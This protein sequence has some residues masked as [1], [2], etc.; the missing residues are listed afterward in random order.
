M[1]KNKFSR[2]GQQF[3]RKVRLKRHISK[4]KRLGNWWKRFRASWV[5][6][7]SGSSVQVALPLFSPTTTITRLRSQTDLSVNRLDN[8]YR[9]NI[10]NPVTNQPQ[11]LDV[12]KRELEEAQKIAVQL[13]R[14]NVN[15]KKVL[16][17]VQGG[18]YELVTTVLITW[19]W[20]MFLQNGGIDGFI[21]HGNKVFFWPN[22]NRYSDHPTLSRFSDYSQSTYSNNG[23]S[24]I[25][26]HGSVQANQFI[27]EMGEVDI[28]KGYK[29]LKQRTK[30][31]N[32]ECTQKRFNEL[33]K[34]PFHPDYTS[35]PNQIEMICDKEGLREALSALE[36]EAKGQIEPIKRPTVEEYKNCPSDFVFIKRTATGY[37]HFEIKNSVSTE[38]LQ[39]KGYNSNLYQHGRNMSKKCLWQKTQWERKNCKTLCAIDFNDSALKERGE[40]LK[41]I[42]SG[43]KV[44]NILQLKDVG[45]LITNLKYNN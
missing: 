34:R 21:I 23:D 7:G 8:K 4:R 32:F 31:L 18:E 10:F 20:I 3:K 45:I 11:M 12:T 41:G 2:F 35:N 42:Y 1:I 30:D 25:T 29:E 19:M 33:C 24:T 38:S 16:G 14:N 27:N 44:S 5:I 36:M 13:Y 17:H 37:T 9:I 26:R 15:F 22:Q 40:I 39:A 6:I 28:D 43:A